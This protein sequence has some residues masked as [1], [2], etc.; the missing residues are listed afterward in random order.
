MQQERAKVVARGPETREPMEK[1]SRRQQKHRLKPPGCGGRREAA[2]RSCGHDSEGVFST[3][4]SPVLTACLGGPG[5][6]VLGRAQGTGLDG[7]PQA[8]GQDVVSQGQNQGPV[9]APAEARRA[10]FSPGSGAVLF[11]SQ[12]LQPECSRDTERIPG[13]RLSSDVYVIILIVSRWVK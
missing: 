3:L 4:T 9:W 6:W 10:V 13:S 1:M 12:R 2:G 8:L 11:Y 5:P 7:V